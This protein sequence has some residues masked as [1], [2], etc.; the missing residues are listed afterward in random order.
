MVSPDSRDGRGYSL[1][2]ARALWPKHEVVTRVVRGG[3]RSWVFLPSPQRVRLVVPAERRAA[4]TALTSFASGR[5]AGVRTAMLATSA[6]LRL[7]SGSAIGPGFSVRPTGTSDP[8][9]AADSLLSG[10]LDQPV[11][12]AW[13]VGP[14]RANR[15]P[16]LQVVGDHAAT[17]AYAKAGID[18]LTTSLVSRESTALAMIERAQFSTLVHPRFW[19]ASSPRARICLC[20]SPS[21]STGIPPTTF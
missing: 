13:T 6:L 17:V 7:R 9:Q 14:A 10:L 20:W 5:P 21:I 4:A 19:G 16:V 15:K 3:R 11:R 8:A 2:V 1:T 12:V 18:S